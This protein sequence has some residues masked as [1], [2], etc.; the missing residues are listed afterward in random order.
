MSCKAK[1]LLEAI[2]FSGKALGFDRNLEKVLEAK[3]RFLMKGKNAPCL[4]RGER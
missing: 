3:A 4:V 2:K 1:S